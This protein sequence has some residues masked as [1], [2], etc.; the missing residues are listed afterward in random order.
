MCYRSP[1]K[2]E[3][4]T[5]YITWVWKALLYKCF[6]W[7]S[8]RKK[9]CTDDQK[10]STWDRGLVR[11]DVD[12]VWSL[13][14]SLLTNELPKE[15]RWW[16]IKRQ[17]DT[18][19]AIPMHTLMIPTEDRSLWMKLLQGKYDREAKIWKKKKEEEQTCSTAGSSPL[20]LTAKEFQA[21]LFSLGHITNRKDLREKL[22]QHYFKSS[23]LM[24]KIEPHSIG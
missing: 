10:N 11:K 5:G 13:L 20:P 18:P 24:N 16:K 12:L 4:N 21:P 17:E 19:P 7:G 23:S 9:A 14:K 2:G 8:F 22:I 3:I 15:S 1:Q 6:V